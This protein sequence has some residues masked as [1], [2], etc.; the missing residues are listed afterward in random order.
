MALNPKVIEWI[1][2]MNLALIAKFGAGAPQIDVTDASGLI[3]ANI[4][5][6]IEEP[7]AAEPSGGAPHLHYARVVN[8][9]DPA[10]SPTQWSV[11][12][13]APVPVGTKWLFLNIGFTSSAANDYV[14][15]MD[16]GYTT[17]YVFQRSQV[18][19][20]EIWIGGF[21]PLGTNRTIY[22]YANNARVVGVYVDIVP[23]FC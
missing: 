18:A 13:S 12:V 14:S 6:I 15:A 4:G 20:Q 9:Y 16:S 19:N 1:T 2:N 22:M 21:Y 8:G 23:Y 11:D 10:A 7:V 17:F 3:T 5:T